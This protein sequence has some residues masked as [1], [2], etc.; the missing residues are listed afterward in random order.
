MPREGFRVDWKKRMSK[1]AVCSYFGERGM[2]LAE[3]EIAGHWVGTYTSRRFD[4]D[5]GR[6]TDE[7]ESV[8][9][10]AVVIKSKPNGCWEHADTDAGK[11]D[12]YGL[13]DIY[14]ECL[15]CDAPRPRK[16]AVRR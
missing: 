3:S 10:L 8:P 4:H 1:K 6:S 16:R 14:G 11:A 15:D 13:R 7:M 9:A 5:A 2:P 12:V